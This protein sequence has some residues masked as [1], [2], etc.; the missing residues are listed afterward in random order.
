M[1]PPVTGTQPFRQ[2][3]YQHPSHIMLGFGIFTA[4]IAQ[5]CNYLHLYC[6]SCFFYSYVL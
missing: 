5:A 2:G 4:G 3:I 6:S 1:L